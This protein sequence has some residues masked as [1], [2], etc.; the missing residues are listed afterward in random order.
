MGYP[1]DVMAREPRKSKLPLSEQDNAIAE[2][3]EILSILIDRLTP[4]LTPQQESPT[5]EPDDRATVTQ[6]EIAEELSN[7]NS[8]IRR[9]TN[10]LNNIL[11]RLEV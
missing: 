4:L 10:K 5:K 9:N 1:E 6:S 2:Q 11:E 8:R 3:N 7:N